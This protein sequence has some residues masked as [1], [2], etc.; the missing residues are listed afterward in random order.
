MCQMSQ[1]PKQHCQ[2]LSDGMSQRSMFPARKLPLKAHCT[3]PPPPIVLPLERFLRGP[4]D[5]GNE[6]CISV[7]RSWRRRVVEMRVEQSWK[8]TSL[9]PP[10]S[11]WAI[12]DKCSGEV[13]NCF[14]AQ[15]H[16]LPTL[17][18]C[19]MTSAYTDAPKPAWM[20]SSLHADGMM[21]L[22]WWTTSPL[23]LMDFPACRQRAV[24]CCVTEASAHTSW[25]MKTAKAHSPI[26]MFY[27]AT[28]T[29]SHSRHLWCCEMWQ[30][31]AHLQP[32]VTFSMSKMEGGVVQDGPL[33]PAQWFQL[34]SL[35]IT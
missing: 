12:P 9:P 31:C 27:E 13:I 26:S 5:T 21:S 22:F 28:S 18:P 30:P 14:M 19:E 2:G 10:L 29:H 17:C 20:P 35:Q 33:S 6:V 11:P 16:C 32:E 4:G 34:D 3:T 8:V 24:W 25:I 15:P 23:E 7:P 1:F